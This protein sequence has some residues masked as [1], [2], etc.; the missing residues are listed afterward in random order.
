MPRRQ[1]AKVKAVQQSLGVIR[2]AI[3]AKRWAQARYALSRARALVGA[4]P[5]DQ[6]VKTPHPV[7]FGPTSPTGAGTGGR[8]FVP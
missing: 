2:T 8:W 1:A 3:N 7:S 6:T 5:A 4:L